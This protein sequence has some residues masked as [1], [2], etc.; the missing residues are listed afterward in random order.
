MGR[1]EHWERVYTTKG[2]QDVSWFETCAVSLQMMEAA[3]LSTST[4][5]LDIGGETLG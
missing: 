2:E 4:C 3:G 1:H 5:V